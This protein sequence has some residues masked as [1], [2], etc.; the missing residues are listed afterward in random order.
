MPAR[1]ISSFMPSSQR[2]PPLATGMMP[3]A[4][5]AAASSL[6]SAHVAGALVAPTLAI[7]ARDRKSV[8]VR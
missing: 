3:A 8:L 5:I 4:F 2:M 7:A 1:A 6:N